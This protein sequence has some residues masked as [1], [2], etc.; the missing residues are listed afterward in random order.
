MLGI[1]I[2]KIIPSKDIQELFKNMFSSIMVRLD[3]GI[4]GSNELNNLC[5]S[6]TGTT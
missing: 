3:A 5:H 6:V 1:Y 4:I 2:Q